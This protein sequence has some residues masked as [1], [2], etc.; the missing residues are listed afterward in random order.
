ME[1]RLALNTGFLVNRYVTPEQWIPF[2]SQNLDIK[3][4]QFTADML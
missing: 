2:V 4:I 1:I 3:R